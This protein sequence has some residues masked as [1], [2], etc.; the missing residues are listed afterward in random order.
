MAPNRQNRLAIHFENLVLN[1]ID[2]IC[3]L[4]IININSVR[5]AAP[6]FQRKTQKQEACQIDLLIQTKYTLYVCEIKFRKIILKSVIG[7]VQEKA[8][9]IKPKKRLSIRPVLIYSG[10]LEQGISEEDY[11]DKIIC[12]EDLL[13]IR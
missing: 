1:N 5:S 9:K 12:F 8:E 13:T 7:N 4:L 10:E 2:S 6:C 3:K 11:F